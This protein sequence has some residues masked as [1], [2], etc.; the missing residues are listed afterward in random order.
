MFGKEQE[1]Q[2]SLA[3]RDQIQAVQEQTLVP[4]CQRRIPRQLQGLDD[5]NSVCDGQLIGSMVNTCNN[6]TR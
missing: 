1:L 4:H 3:N 5:V 6:D 2:L